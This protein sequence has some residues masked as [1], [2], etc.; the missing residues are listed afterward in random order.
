LALQ[1]VDHQEN[2]MFP[3]I[4][5]ITD[6]AQRTLLFWDVMRE[7]GNQYREHARAS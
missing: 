3:A 7:R 6:S 1:S 5:Y 2:P 4:E